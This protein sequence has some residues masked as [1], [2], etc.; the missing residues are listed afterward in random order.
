MRLLDK[1]TTVAAVV[2]I[3]AMHPAIAD[4]Q[5]AKELAGTWSLV[6]ET[7]EQNGKTIQPYGPS[8]KGIQIFGS[9]GHY[10]LIVVNPDLPKFASD[11][12]VAGTAEEN[13]A[14]VQGSMAY[15]GA[16]AVDDAGKTWSVQIEGATFPNWMGRSE[17]RTFAIAGDVLTVSIPKAST[18]LAATL[19][20]RR[21]K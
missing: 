10:A 15:F 11:N 16:Y 2:V 4:A 1:I 12:R 19:V 18:G 6:S 17:K 7:Y 14:V 3:S 21:V 13:K 8:P 5:A 9:D 20:W